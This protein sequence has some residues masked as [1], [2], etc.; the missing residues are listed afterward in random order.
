MPSDRSPLL[1]DDARRE[2]VSALLSDVVDGM[3]DDDDEFLHELQTDLRFQAELVQYRKLLRAL[4][5]LRTD[6]V[7]PGPSLVDDVLVILDEHVERHGIL[8]A[9]TPRRAVC[10]GGI[11][12]ATAAGVGTALVLVRR[13]AA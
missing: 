10:F 1:L 12:A 2:R 9:F 8:G 6:V 7:D 11:A 4:R 3:V 13:R 5:A